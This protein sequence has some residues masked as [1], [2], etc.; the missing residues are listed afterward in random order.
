MR[1]ILRRKPKVDKYGT[2]SKAVFL[3]S[4]T[5]D[6]G[7]FGSGDR[8]RLDLLVFTSQFAIDTALMALSDDHNLSEEW[9][10]VDA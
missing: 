8:G 7:W 4:Y 9:E 6:G 5:K 3:V 1:K 2:A 10:A